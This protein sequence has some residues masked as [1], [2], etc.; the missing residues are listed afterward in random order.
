MELG[1]RAWKEGAGT[2]QWCNVEVGRDE[3][4]CDEH[5]D[6]EIISTDDDGCGVEYNN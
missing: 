1:F 4:G 6:R 2:D 5:G 3:S